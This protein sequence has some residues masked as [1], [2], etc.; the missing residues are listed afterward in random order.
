ML[1]FVGLGVLGG[2][3]VLVG[4]GVGFGVSGAVPVTEGVGVCD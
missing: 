1:E 2:V 4:L 3:E